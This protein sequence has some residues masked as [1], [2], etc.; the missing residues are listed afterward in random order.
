MYN[1]LRESKNERT[2]KR[3]LKGMSEKTQG[4]LLIPTDAD[5]QYIRE[6]ISADRAKAGPPP[7]KTEFLS[8]MA[9]LETDAVHKIDSGYAL[10]HFITDPNNST[11][12]L[13]DALVVVSTG[14]ISTS[15]A[16]VPILDHIV[17]TPVLIVAPALE[18][19]ALALL[20]INKFRGIL[21]V[22]AITTSTNEEVGRYLGCKAAPIQELRRDDLGSARRVVAGWNFTIIE[23]SR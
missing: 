22:C 17:G 8:V 1:G 6:M 19:E 21:Q 4:G 18:L 7:A 12:E 16:L 13:R 3:G 23:K 14:T 10:P 5:I 2:C 20:L 11:C 9:G 15:R